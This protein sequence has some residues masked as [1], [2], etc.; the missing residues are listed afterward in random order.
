MIPT[1]PPRG[2]I[3]AG[4]NHR[5]HINGNV[6]RKAESRENRVN[7]RVLLKLSDEKTIS[8]SRK[9]PSEILKIISL[10][11]SNRL[12]NPMLKLKLLITIVLIFAFSFSL[13]P[14]AFVIADDC[15]DGKS[16]AGPTFPG[17]AKIS[18]EW[19]LTLKFDPN[20]PEEITCGSQNAIAISVI[21]GCPPFT[22][23]VLSD[24]YTLTDIPGNIRAKTLSCTGDT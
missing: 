5:R 17:N 20:N 14:S 7:E 21:D 22:W 3:R 10:C 8:L 13:N 12:R 9:Q 24:G 16:G 15:Q 6:L 11:N 23:Q 18:P 1:Q 4:W 19:K 2:K